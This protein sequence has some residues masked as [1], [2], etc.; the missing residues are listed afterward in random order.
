MTDPI[1]D[2]HRPRDTDARVVLTTAP[3]RETAERLGR[4]LVAERLVAC[5]NVVD[6]ITSIYRWEGD[7][8]RDPE[9]LVIFKTTGERVDAVVGRVAELHPYDV[10]EV[11]ALPVV[12][13]HGPYLTWVR[14]ASSEE[15]SAGREA[16]GGRDEGVRA[17]PEGAG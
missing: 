10:P 11:I 17:P 6:G 7:V 3:D 4:L 14:D 8:E 12:G 1:A 15:E 5:A 9:T 13:G 2:R 16:A